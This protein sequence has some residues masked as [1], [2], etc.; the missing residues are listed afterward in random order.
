M[1]QMLNHL[2]TVRGDVAKGVTYAVASMIKR[3][4]SGLT[5]FDNYFFYH[6]ELVKEDLRWLFFKR[7]LS[8]VFSSEPTHV[9]PGAPFL[10]S[11]I[12]PGSFRKPPILDYLKP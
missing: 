5:K 2:Y 1:H 10:G 12:T 11:Q 8:L 4:G 7:E 6:D 9:H 3:T